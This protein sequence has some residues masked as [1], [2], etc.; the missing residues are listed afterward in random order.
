MKKIAIVTRCIIAGGIEKALISMINSIDRSK[1]KIT[2]FVMAKGGEFEKFISGN[3]EII[4]IYGYEKTTKEKIINNIKEGNIIN[5]VK[6]LFYTYI[7]LNSRPG[8]EQEKYLAKILPK[9]KE[10]YDLAIAYHVPASFPVIYVINHLNA[11]NKVGWIHSDAT[12]YKKQIDKYYDY[13]KKFNKIYLV[14]KEG[15]E[16]FI[17]LYPDLSRKSEVFHNIISRDEIINLSQKGS[18]F[19]D[20][21]KGIRILTVGRITHEKGH[22]LI[23]EICKK[24]ID[25]KYNIRWY[26]IGDG[27][28]RDELQEQIN[29]YN[30]DNIV[31]LLGVKTN[32]YKYMKECDIYVQPSKEE[33]YC[34]TIA[35]AKCLSK[36]I[37]FTN[38]TGAEEQI[39]H[40]KTGFIAEFDID[41]IYKYLVKLIDDRELRDKLSENLTNE[42][43]DTREEINKLYSILR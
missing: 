1:Y 24:L 11:R 42:I 28:K 23:P 36:P 12:K 37:I 16:K 13:Y 21:F 17:G 29:N 18:G 7:A 25:N 41:S 19:R 20:K 31:H 10:G 39:K 38:V 22:I 35:E 9:H 30:L 43:V 5:A 26:C 34:I 32:P 15:K 3:I 2:I 33:G 27:D 40:G 14:S 6:I 4:P 8:Y